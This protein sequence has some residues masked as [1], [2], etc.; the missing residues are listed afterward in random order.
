MKHWLERINKLE[1]RLSDIQWK[2]GYTFCSSNIMDHVFAVFEKHGDPAEVDG[3]FGSN[4]YKINEYTME[5]YH[6]QGE[7]G[8][9]I[10]IPNRIF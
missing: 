1:K 7:Y 6:G 10:T 3:M 5:I 9:S 8:Y 4:A 2:K